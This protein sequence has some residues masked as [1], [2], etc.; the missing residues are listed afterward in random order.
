[1]SDLA[2]ELDGSFIGLCTGVADEDLGGIPHGTGLNGLLNKQLAESSG[3]RVV[4]QVGGMD[5]GFGLK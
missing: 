4:I 5:E 2:C 3:P 1:M